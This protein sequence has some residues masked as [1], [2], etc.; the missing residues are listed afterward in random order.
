LDDERT[1][2]RLIEIVL[3]QFRVWTTVILNL[4]FSSRFSQNAEPS[5]RFSLGYRKI[6]KEPD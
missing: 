5:L 4:R 2:S 6:L 1:E 3:V